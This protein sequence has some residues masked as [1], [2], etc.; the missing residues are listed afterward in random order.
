LSRVVFKVLIDFFF[1]HFLISVDFY[2]SIM[3]AK[4]SKVDANPSKVSSENDPLDFSSIKRDIK[5]NLPGLQSNILD[6]LVLLLQCT[7]EDNQIQK[8]HSA[9]GGITEL[10]LRAQPADSCGRPYSKDPEGSGAES[11]DLPRAALEF[12]V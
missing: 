3:A 4:S 7:N 8:I 12:P 5:G 10:Y 6:H 1:L 11:R 9:L 2:Q